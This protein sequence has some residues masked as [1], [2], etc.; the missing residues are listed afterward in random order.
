MKN[1]PDNIR[2]LFAKDITKA[3]ISTKDMTQLLICL[4]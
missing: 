1:V 3:Q 2:V 4:F